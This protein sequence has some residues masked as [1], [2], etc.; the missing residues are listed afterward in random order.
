MNIL[1]TGTKRQDMFM[2]IS[3]HEALNK[4]AGSGRLFTELFTHGTLSVEI[5]KPLRVD[6]QQPHDRD[7][8]YV[9]ISGSGRFYCQGAVSDFKAGDFFFVKAGM[10]HH[11]MDFSD[12]FATWVFFYGPPGGESIS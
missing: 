11:F 8:V 3:A 2:Q 7:E 10:D 4:L 6:F 9:V 12:D 5:Y 1:E